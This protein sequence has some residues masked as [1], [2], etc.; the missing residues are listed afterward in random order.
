MQQKELVRCEGGYWRDPVYPQNPFLERLENSHHPQYVHCTPLSPGSGTA[1]KL[2]VDVCG[3]PKLV[4]W[5]DLYGLSKD[6]S[7]KNIS[8]N[9]LA[10]AF[11]LASGVYFHNI[12]TDTKGVVVFYARDTVDF[13]ILSSNSNLAYLRSSV[14]L[15]ASVVS[16]KKPRE[17]AIKKKREELGIILQRVQTKLLILYN[18]GMLN[19]L[20]DDSEN[21]STQLWSSQYNGSSAVRKI[22]VIG[23]RV[24]FYLNEKISTTASKIVK[25]GGQNP[26][27]PLAKAQVLFAFFG[28]FFSLITLSAINEGMK[29]KSGGDISMLFP[30]FGALVTCHYGLTGA[31][32]SQPR[33]SFL[34][35]LITLTMATSSTYIPVSILPV[36]VRIPVITSIG[37]AT[38]LALGLV[39]PPAGGVCVVF[40]QTVVPAWVSMG[41]LLFG[42]AEAI[43]FAMVFINLHGSAT[44]PMYWGVSN[45]KKWFRRKSKERILECIAEKRNEKK[46]AE[47]P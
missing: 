4:K 1:G 36:W 31:P 19:T 33:N 15:L 24:A 39:H 22:V 20:F 32:A 46:Y 25:S 9:I 42:Y 17:N 30:P 29:H 45:P 23:V 14:D 10:Q 5:I 21:E 7:H 40:S 37:I 13:K 26:P 28:S 12:S 3:N 18:L 16:W 8:L 43:F 47:T 34:G 38:T 27:R 2:W 35:L 6:A 41:V 44:F 11:G